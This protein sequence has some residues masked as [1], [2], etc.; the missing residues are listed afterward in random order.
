MLYS[1]AAEHNCCF[2]SS[3]LV[4]GP[5]QSLHWDVCYSTDGSRTTDGHQLPEPSEKCHL[6]FVL[7]KF[8]GATYEHVVSLQKES[9]FLFG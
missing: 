1:Q 5:M 8:E 7:E 2:I 4:P 6:V 3:D 9:K